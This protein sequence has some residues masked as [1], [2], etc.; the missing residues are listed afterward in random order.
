MTKFVADSSCDVLEVKG[1]NFESVP[2]TISTG[3]E[4]FV[5]DKNLERGKMLDALE[6]HK[7]RSYTSCPSV[8][9]WLKAFEGAD[10]IY[11]G[12]MTSALSGTYNSAMTARKLYLQEHP[13][14]RICIID[15]LSTG[16][17]LF[18]LMEKYMELDKMGLSFEEISEEA[19]KYLKTTRMFYTLRSLH[20]L[21]QNGRV[22]KAV[23]AAIGVLG[24]RIVGTA[25]REGRVEPVAKCRGDKKAVGTLI[26]LIR[27]A[28][29]KPGGKIR[30]GHTENP[31]LMEVM[32]KE[33]EANFPDARIDTYATGGLCGYYGER[34]A[35]FVGVETTREF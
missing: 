1:V 6:N 25:S 35:I 16:P 4:E 5:D 34:G 20:N 31:E 11:V 33:I 10:T 14:A 15:T 22:N 7:G 27:E 9:A 3:T 13:D 2:L 24:I 8:D 17:E 19:G 21:A 29:F 23:A 32:R 18:L 30:L 28:G 26:E 12:T